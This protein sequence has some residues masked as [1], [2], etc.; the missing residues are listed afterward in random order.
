M[1]TRR[2]FGLSCVFSYISSRFIDLL[3]VLF[4]FCRVAITKLDVLDTLAEI[5]IGIAYYLNGVELDALPG[6]L[7]EIYS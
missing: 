7:V 4:D 1:D 2:E 5:K 3:D 6:M